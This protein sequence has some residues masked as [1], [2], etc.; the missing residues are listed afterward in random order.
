MLGHWGYSSTQRRR[1]WGWVCRRLWIVQIS[2]RIVCTKQ[3]RPVSACCKTYIKC[4]RL[5][6][7]QLY[8]LSR[9]LDKCWSQFYPRSPCSQWCNLPNNRM[10]SLSCLPHR[11]RTPVRPRYFQYCTNAYSLS[12]HGPLATLS[13]LLLCPSYH[14]SSIASISYHN[15]RPPLSK[16]YPCSTVNYGSRWCW[17]TRQPKTMP[18]TVLGIRCTGCLIGI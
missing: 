1:Y 10:N 18:S 17:C 5:H 8:N 13:H 7:P 15:H 12:N 4:Q 6:R 3:W 14:L 9:T 11:L 2:L 16:S